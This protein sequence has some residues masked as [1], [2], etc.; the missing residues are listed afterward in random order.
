M[1]NFF[2]V[3]G[4]KDLIVTHVSNTLNSSIM[5][6]KTSMAFENCYYKKLLNAKLITSKYGPLLLFLQR[7][8]TTPVN[9]Y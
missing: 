6:C 5:F 1:I 3:A 7:I 8:L 9:L 4:I 2:P